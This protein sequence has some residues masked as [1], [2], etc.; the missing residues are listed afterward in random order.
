MKKK[1]PIDYEKVALDDLLNESS[2]D[3]DRPPAKKAR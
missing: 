3:S 1:E 2:S